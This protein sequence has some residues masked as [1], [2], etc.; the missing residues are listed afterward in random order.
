[1]KDKLSI[2]K[3]WPISH[4]EYEMLEKEF[5]KLIEHQ[6]WD[7]IRRN[8]KSNFTDDQIDIA[9]T[10]RIAMMKAGSY[11]KR[12]IYIEKCIDLCKSL[13]KNSSDKKVLKNLISLW[14]NKTKHGANKQKFGPKE[15]KVLNK[16]MI[17]VVPKEQHPDK[18]LKLKIDALFTR[19][20]KAITWNEQ[21]NL[22]KKITRER[23]IRENSVSLSEYDSMIS[24]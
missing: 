18:N 16:L 19:Y 2:C 23:G 17:K 6:A 1:M 10:L 22:G 7:L 5:G 14:N 8:T 15:E 21:K 11:Y 12:Q 3:E 20:C 9:Q 4:E 13:C 24:I